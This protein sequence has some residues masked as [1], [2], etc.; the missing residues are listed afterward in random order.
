MLALTVAVPS[1]DM[2]S[3]ILVTRQAA[4]SKSF[5]YVRMALFRELVLTKVRNTFVQAKFV[6]NKRGG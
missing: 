1:S 3:R 5:D 4:F 2:N 6:Y